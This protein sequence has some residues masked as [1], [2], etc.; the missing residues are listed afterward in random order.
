MP[1][2]PAPA[3]WARPAGPLGRI[4]PTGIAILLCIV[5][6][7]IYTLVY[8]YQTHEEMK[9]HS[10]DGLG[11]GLALVIALFVGIV[12]PSLLSNEVGTL[13]ER[14]GRAKPVSAVTALWLLLPIAG[15]I[16]WF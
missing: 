16:V 7:G 8:Y 1:G 5:T 10:G 9:R 14:T 6:L 4:R 13:Y 12:S 11:G 3:Q 2:V 15:P